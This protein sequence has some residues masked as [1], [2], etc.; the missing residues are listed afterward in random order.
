[1][2]KDRAFFGFISEKGPVFLRSLVE[3]R[4]ALADGVHIKVIE[5]AI[6]KA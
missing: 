2:Q 6:S 1:M 4:K 5:R 3:A